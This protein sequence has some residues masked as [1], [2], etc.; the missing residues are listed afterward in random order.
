MGTTCGYCNGPSDQ[1]YCSDECRD[2]SARLGAE[3]AM[4]GTPRLNRAQRRTIAR[5]RKANARFTLRHAARKH[6]TAG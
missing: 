2:A 4:T 1:H 3:L 5:G 6:G